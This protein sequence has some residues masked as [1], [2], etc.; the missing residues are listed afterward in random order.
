LSDIDLLFTAAGGTFC[1]PPDTLRQK[2]AGARA[3]IFDWDGVFNNGQKGD[4]TGSPFSEPDSMGVNLLRF[5]FWLCRGRIPSTAILTGEDNKG[6][7]YLAQREHY[8]AVYF[9]SVDKLKSFHH[10]LQS[11]Q[12]RPEEVV[13]V[14]DDV[15]D[16]ALASVCGVRIQVRRSAS[17][18][19]N[20]FVVR[21]SMT[22]YIT[23]HDGSH[24]AVREACELMIGLQGNFGETV[25]HRMNFSERYHEYLRERNQQRTDIYYLV[26]GEVRASAK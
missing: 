1:T 7:L 5:S 16:L 23:G 18:L 9:K 3:V 13:F 14:Y 10:F 24:F 2:L 21:N 8:A 20:S 6:A 12:I 15:L 25:E 17:P 4:P 22:D 11:Q 19:F 26:D